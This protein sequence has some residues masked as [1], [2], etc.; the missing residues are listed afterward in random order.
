LPSLIIFPWM[1]SFNCSEIVRSSG[2]S[3]I[4]SLPG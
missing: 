2:N 4:S 1:V 3:N